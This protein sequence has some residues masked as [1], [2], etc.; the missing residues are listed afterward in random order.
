MKYIL[1]IVLVCMLVSG[2]QAQRSLFGITYDV[3][4]PLGDMSD[5]IDKTS[6]RG[7]GLEGRWFYRPQITF[8]LDWAWHTFH[9]QSD[10]TIEI[11]NG[12]ATGHQFRRIYAS[13]ILFTMH[14]YLQELDDRQ[15]YNIYAG[16]GIGTYWIEEKLDLG[17]VTITDSN[18]HF[19][20]A[21]EV[22]LMYQ[23]KYDTYFYFNCKYNYAFSTSGSIDYSFLGLNV[24]FIYSSF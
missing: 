19:G 15:P 1:A 12:A 20:L 22:G 11:E 18:W 23:V 3:S 24:G 2:A 7:F 4:I 5:Y 6:W 21:P 10:E 8:G 9:M 13:P 16:L 14:Y 17:I